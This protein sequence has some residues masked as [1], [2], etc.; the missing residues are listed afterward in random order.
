[1]VKELNS[2][3]AAVG[4]LLDDLALD[5]KG[6]SLASVALVLAAKLDDARD[7]TS[8]AVSVAVPGIAK[9]L[10]AILDELTIDSSETMSFVDGL[11]GRSA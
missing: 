9:E 6:Q 4:A 3:T 2:V 10:V 1:M 8:G 11:F 5:F 7:S